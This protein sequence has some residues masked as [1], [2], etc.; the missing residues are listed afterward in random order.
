MLN[1]LFIILFLEGFIT[2]SV[3]IIIM[4]QLL[5]FFG[6]SVV[7]TSIIIGVFLLFLALGYWRGGSYK[8]DFFK[9]LSRNFMLSML[10]IGVG[11][12]YT[13]IAGFYYLSIY[14]IHLSYLPS[15][16]FYLLIVLAPIVYWLGQT[17]PLTT[18]LFNQEQRV[19]HISGR[20]L[21]LST[22]GSFMGALLTS[23]LLFQ[24]LGVAWTIVIN[25]LLLFILLI[26]IRVHGELSWGGV[27][28]LLLALLFIQI[29]NVQAENAQF[30][31]TNNYANYRVINS[32]D[33]SKIFQINLSNSSMLT[34]DKKGFAYIELLRDILFNKLALQHKKILVVGAGGFTLTAAGTHNNEVLYVDIDPEIKKIAETHFLNQP[35]QG[36]FIGQ[37]ARS[38]LHQTNQHFDV[39]LSDVY[40]HQAT[41]PASLL[42]QEYFQGLA[43]HLN[44]GG[45]LV[46][47]IIANPLFADDYAQIVFNTIHAVFPYC[48]VI[49]FNW[50]KSLAN[51]IY[52]CPKVGKNETLYRDDLNTSTLDFFK[53][54]P[55]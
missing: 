26:Y 10:W 32:F 41:I 35:I 44:P 27:L 23:L 51:M 18:N 42:T 39:I 13:L 46:V 45:L 47:N 55:R 9:Q 15:L 16:V 12:S 21:F 19:S 25:C 36:T 4:R 53:N 30:K 28:L 31:Q 11:L 6:G 17:V 49:P 7:I 22:I 43:D 8:Q 20:A 5:P 29:L 1:M 14:Q 38:Y 2:I 37:D 3:E 52:I 54:H 33:F 40:S 24:Y 50:Q 48:T 34:A